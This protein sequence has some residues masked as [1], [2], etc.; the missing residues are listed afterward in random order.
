[1]RNSR[2]GGSREVFSDKHYRGEPKLVAL[3]CQQ[4]ESRMGRRDVREFVQR[5][6]RGRGF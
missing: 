2:Y 4:R 3:R 5:E 6:T 1:M